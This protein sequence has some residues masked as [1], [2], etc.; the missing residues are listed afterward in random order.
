MDMLRRLLSRVQQQLALM[1][2]SQQMAIGL[3]AVIIM[4]SLMWMAQWTSQPQLEPLLDQPMTVDEMNT[5]VEQ[6]NAMRAD[7][8]ERGD[9]IYVKPEERRKLQR[10][11]ASQGA[12][13]QDTSLGFENLLEGQSPF[14]PESINRRNFTIALQ[15]ELASVIAA[16]SEVAKSRVFIN[17]VKRR[18]IGALQSLTPTASVDISMV[19]GRQMGQAAVQAVAN[20]VSGAVGGLEPHNVKVIVDGRPR[21][22]PAPDEAFSAGLL[23]EKK[24]NEKHLEEKV[25][26]HLD[27][28]P[29]VKVAVAVELETVKKKTISREYTDPAPKSDKSITEESNSGSQAS[30]P[31]VNPNTGTALSAGGRGQSTTKDQSESEFFPANVAKVE[32]SEQIPLTVKS[33]TASVG[34]PRSYFVSVY[35]AQ[36]G[37]DQEPTDVDLKSLIDIEKLR[38]RATVKNVIG[39]TDDDAVQVDWFPDLAPGSPGQFMDSPL[40]AQTDV[41]DEGTVASLAHYGPQAGLVGL[42]LVSLMMMLMLARKSSRSTGQLPLPKLPALEEEELITP[43]QSAKATEGFLVGQ[44][45][46]EETLRFQNLNDQVSVMV[47]ENPEAAADL[48]RRWVEQD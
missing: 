17:D 13:P 18:G 38:V 6:L 11:L 29:G 26:G 35:K 16:S 20:L 39:T 1:T 45:V 28:I 34:I 5:A 46:D 30:E 12:L 3:C 10:Q 42:A 33:V 40:L 27:Y 24:K 43:L 25:Y 22:I 8:E 14:V 2:R 9:R 44:E 31:G 15:N 7:F 41:E 47:D 23:D 32:E 19:G 36:Q 48:V 4:G 21:A 37:E